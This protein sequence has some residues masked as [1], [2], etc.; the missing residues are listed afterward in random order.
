MLDSRELLKAEEAIDCHQVR[1]RLTSPI[2]LLSVSC[3]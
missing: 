1:Y 3:R 2:R